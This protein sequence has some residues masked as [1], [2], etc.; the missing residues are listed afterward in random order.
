MTDIYVKLVD[1]QP[2]EP[3]INKDNHLNYNLD[4]PQ[5]IA[6]GYKILVQQF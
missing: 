5:L 2:Q 4:I 1:G 3:P 6:D